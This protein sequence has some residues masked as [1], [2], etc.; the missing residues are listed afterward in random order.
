MFKPSIVWAVGLGMAALGTLASAA[1]QGTSG[2]QGRGGGYMP[3]Q[4][5][6]FSG[7]VVYSIN[8]PTGPQTQQ[9]PII[10]LGPAMGNAAFAAAEFQ[11][12]S[13]ALQIM[14]ELARN[15][16]RSSSE[17]VAAKTELED[18]QRA[19]DDAQETVLAKLRDDPQYKSLLT[20]R[21]EEQVALSSV[22][23]DSPMR[24][25]VA[26]TKLGFGAQVTMLEAKAL[27]EDRA[28]QDARGRLI[29][30]RKNLTGREKQFEA[31]LYNQPEI[32][33]ARQQLE[34]ARVNKAAAQAYLVGQEIARNDQLNQI[35]Q[36]NS[37]NVVIASYPY[38]P[39][40]GW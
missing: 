34:T 39:V 35:A 18:A 15:Q 36:S 28:F 37:G 12:R 16:F 30:A 22:S 7:P 5:G 23:L 24:F 29:A 25:E 10:D 27:G 13:A 11:N 14:I 40:W 20:K 38:Y 31:G 4:G 19:Y 33:A 17:M 6:G 2:S 3:W 9:E 26:M 8:S 21:T 32:A 1:Q